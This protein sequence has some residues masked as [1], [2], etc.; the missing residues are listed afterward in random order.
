MIVHIAR[1]KEWDDA[2]ESGEYTPADFDKFI[3]CS[4]PDDVASVAN[5]DFSGEDDLVLLW[6]DPPKVKAGIIYERAAGQEVG[7]L[8]PHIY[9]PLNIDA[10]LK[11]DKLK[12]WEAGGFV[13]PPQPRQ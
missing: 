4:T 13:L 5:E 8:F 7:P 11:A 1:Q 10:V 9:G 3:H 12:P 2:Q 6:I